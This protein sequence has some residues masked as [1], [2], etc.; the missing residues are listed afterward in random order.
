MEVSLAQER[1]GLTNRGPVAHQERVRARDDEVIGQTGDAGAGDRDL[2][3]VGTGNEQAVDPI[4]GTVAG[5]N[6]DG[7][8]YRA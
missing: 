6:A 3:V 4:D 1:Q 2:A 7:T 8:A 5:D